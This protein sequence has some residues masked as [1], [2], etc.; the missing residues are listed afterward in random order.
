ML[1]SPP[2]LT[3]KA[4]QKILDMLSKTERLDLIADIH[5]KV[6]KNTECYEANHVWLKDGRYSG[7][8]LGNSIGVDL[9]YLFGA[10]AAG[11]IDEILVVEGSTNTAINPPVPL[12]ALVCLLCEL[13]PK[14]HPIWAFIA[15]NKD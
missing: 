12:S 8:G 3:L 7:T 14:T 1:Y 2:K 15:W 6:F 9:A 10:I 5:A 11:S 13:Y 4:R